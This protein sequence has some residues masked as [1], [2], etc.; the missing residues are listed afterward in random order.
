MDEENNS[1]CDSESSTSPNRGEVLLISPGGVREALFADEYY[2]IVWGK[3][4][5]FAR[6]AIL[7]NQPIYPVFTE[8]VREAIRVVQFGKRKFLLFYP[9]H[10]FSFRPISH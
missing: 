10:A 2:S 8:N 3:R 6:V 9:T 1:A 4:R 7:A 5:G